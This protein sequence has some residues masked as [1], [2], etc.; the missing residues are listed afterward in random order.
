MYG[1]E[2]FRALLDTSRDLIA[3]VDE[4]GVIQYVNGAADRLLGYGPA[5]LVGTNSTQYVH[6][7]DE[8]HLRAALGEVIENSVASTVTVEFRFRAKDGSWVRLES[9]FSSDETPALGGFVVNAREMAETGGG[10]VAYAQGRDRDR[11]HELAE[12]SN[13]VLWMFTADWDELLFVNS[14]YEQ[15]WGRSV[16]ALR[17]N[18]TDFLDG[19]HPADRERVKQAMERLSNGTPVDIEYRVNEGEDYN[20][21]VWVQG[22]P[23]FEG[24]DVVR[25]VGFARDVSERHER[26][27]Q[28]QVIDRLLRHN[29]RNSMNIVLGYATELDNRVDGSLEPIARLQ[30]EG[31]RLL[32]LA[33]KQRE[34]VKILTTEVQSTAV[35]LDQVVEETVTAL[36][37]D[38]PVENVTVDVDSTATVRAFPKIGLAVRELVVNA[39]EHSESAT[40]EVSVTVRTAEETVV[41]EVSDS[42]PVI[43]AQNTMVL[44]GEREIE[45]LFHGDGVGLWLV[46]W[47]FERSNGTVTFTSTE[48]RGNCVRGVL[49]RA[50]LT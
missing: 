4:D 15:I 36:E 32:S 31:E 47:L 37:S 41:L 28:L 14:A 33:D 50:D 10:Q 30:A 26:T 46:Y 48:P 40:P 45:D 43:P 25:V 1:R 35:D 42:N 20:H 21:W 3:V 44:T 9:R 11:L 22:E 49:P 13:E 27:R 23:I 38:H 24:D 5:E 18:A 7:E 6:P 29:L 12:T 34:L 39:L 16:A 17:D 8:P 19:I 2:Q